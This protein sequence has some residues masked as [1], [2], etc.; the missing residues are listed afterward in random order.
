MDLSEIVNS[1]IAWFKDP[2]LFAVNGISQQK[3]SKLEIK[4]LVASYIQNRDIQPVTA[5][6]VQKLVTEGMGERGRLQFGEVT[7]K[8][9]PN[10][11]HVLGEWVRL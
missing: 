6:G 4:D 2:S 8:L 7:A 1:E 5:S 9:L 11:E 3:S 10:V